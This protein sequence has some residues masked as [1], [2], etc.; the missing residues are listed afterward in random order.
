MSKVA[1]V[2]LLQRA[3][4]RITTVEGDMVLTVKLTKLLHCVRRHGLTADDLAQYL[5][6]SER[7][8]AELLDPEDC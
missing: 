3:T 8:L 4:A 7:S 6:Q 5:R 2:R 1:P